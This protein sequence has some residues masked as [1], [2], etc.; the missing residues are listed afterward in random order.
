[1]KVIGFYTEDEPLFASSRK[2]I[3]NKVVHVCTN[4][5]V[6]VVQ[7]VK[8]SNADRLLACPFLSR[9]LCSGINT[10]R[11]NGTR[12]IGTTRRE[13]HAREEKP[14]CSNSFSFILLL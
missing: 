2:Q 8:I 14:F 9:S 10:Q 1:M 13:R 11:N 7:T 3:D 12:R 5:H 6:R 4:M